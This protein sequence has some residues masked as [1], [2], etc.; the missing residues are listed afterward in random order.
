MISIDFYP[1]SPCGERLQQAIKAE[2]TARISIHALLAESD[3]VFFG[4][5]GH[6]LRNFYPRSPCGERLTMPDLCQRYVGISIHALLAESDFD[7]REASGKFFIF[8]STLSLRRATRYR[9]RDRAQ[10]EHFYPRSP[11]GERPQHLVLWPP[12]KLFLST[13]S[14]RRATPGP[15]VMTPERYY[16]YPRSPCGERLT[17]LGVGLYLVT[18][19]IHALLAESDKGHVG[20]AQLHIVISIHALLAESDYR[21][22]VPG[23]PPYSFLSTL[24]LRRATAVANPVGKRYVISIHALL[25]ESDQCPNPCRRR[26]RYFYPRSPC[27][28]RRGIGYSPKYRHNFYPRSP[29][30]ERLR[31]CT[32][33]TWPLLFLSTLSLRRATDD[34]VHALTN[35]GLFL[36]TLSLRRATS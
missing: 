13:L 8:L 36:S 22:K 11:C 19:S 18:I 27:G 20:N 21:R 1:R 26:C 6:K 28:E 31:R 24:S 14:L 33:P 12:V 2:Q 32:M 29:C 16:F 23:C 17:G 25:A 9:N 7:G 10:S 34:L 3:G 5:P 15:K 35:N 30:G 4:T